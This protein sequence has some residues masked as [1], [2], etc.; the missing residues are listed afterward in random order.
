MMEIYLD[1]ANTDEITEIL[2][3][4]II[5][6]VTT[7]QKIFLN[8]KGCNFEER[9]KQ[10]LKMVKPYPVSLEGP[11]NLNELLKTARKYNLWGK[12]VVIKVPMLADGNGLKAVKILESEG[13]KTNVTA[14][15]SINQAFLAIQA[16]ASYASLFFNRIRDSGA[17]PVDVVKQ[18][19]VIIDNGDFKTKLIVGSIRNPSDVED[20]IS[21]NPHIITIPYKILKQMPYHE[22]TVSTLQEFDIA[23]DEFIKAEKKC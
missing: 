12:N 4:G 5:K 19:R 18:S 8:E 22:K 11:N 3:W 16:G 1:T 23:W 15:M 2:E 14:M 17:N 7:N 10:I 13:I 20:I 9:S 6:G 21:A